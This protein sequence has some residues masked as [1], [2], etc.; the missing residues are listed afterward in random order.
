M[1]KRTTL[2]DNATSPLVKLVLW[3]DICSHT[4]E[5]RCRSEPIATFQ[6]LQH[7][8]SSLCCTLEKDH[9]DA[10]SVPILQFIWSIMKRPTLRKSLKVSTY[11]LQSKPLSDHKRHTGRDLTRY[12]KYEQKFFSF[13]RWLPNR[14]SESP[15]EELTNLKLSR[16]AHSMMEE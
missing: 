10:V 3:G 7:S 5:R 8:N 13:K 6:P 14:R 4:V 9:T 15:S 1:E 2:V 12:T 11:E 16:Q